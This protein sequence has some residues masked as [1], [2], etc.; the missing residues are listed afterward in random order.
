MTRN[1][2]RTS[3]NPAF[4]GILPHH[5]VELLLWHQL[6]PEVHDIFLTTY[7]T[8]QTIHYHDPN[9]LASQRTGQS[10]ARQKPS[11]YA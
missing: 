3:L 7:K 6:L 11:D 4:N 8:F 9:N 1:C 10:Y 5:D 2:H